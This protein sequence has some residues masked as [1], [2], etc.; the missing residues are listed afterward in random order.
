MITV[1][2]NTDFAAR[3]RDDAKKQLWQLVLLG[4]GLVLLGTVVSD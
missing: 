2:T 1:P 3:N 4:W